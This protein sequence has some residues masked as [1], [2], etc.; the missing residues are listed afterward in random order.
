ML[1]PKAYGGGGIEIPCKYKLHGV[2]KDKINV[3]MKK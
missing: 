2:K 3:F 1:L